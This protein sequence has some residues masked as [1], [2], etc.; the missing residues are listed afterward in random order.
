MWS[1]SGPPKPSSA[2]AALPSASNRCLY[3]GSTQARATTLAPFIGPMS[4]AYASTTWSMNSALTIPFSVKSSSSARARRSTSLSGSGWC[5]WSSLMSCGLEVTVVQVDVHGHVR[6]GG[7]GPELA[8]VEPHCVRRVEHAF[9]PVRLHLGDGRHHVDPRD[10]TVVT[11]HV[12]GAPGVTAEVE[13]ADAHGVAD[14]E[15][16]GLAG[17]RFANVVG[18]HS[19][20]P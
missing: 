10:D 4:W 2:I 6:L 14:G 13:V 9:A 16:R 15:A 7:V 8:G 11:P 20:R 18:V 5:P 3:S 12:P 19:G 1:P 17:H